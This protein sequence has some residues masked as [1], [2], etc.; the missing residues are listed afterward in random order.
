MNDLSE[1]STYIRVKKTAIRQANN[2][3][4]QDAPKSSMFKKKGTELFSSKKK[5]GTP[6]YVPWC[7]PNPDVCSLATSVLGHLFLHLQ[8]NRFQNEGGN[9]SETVGIPGSSFCV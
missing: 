5:V 6:Q 2:L 7:L 1:S 9:E 4:T 3:G 8:T